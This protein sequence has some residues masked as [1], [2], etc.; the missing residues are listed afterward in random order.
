M[1]RLLFLG[2]SFA[3]LQAFPKQ[4]RRVA[5]VELQRVQEGGMPRDWK[6]MPN[7]GQGVIEIHLHAEAGA[8][9]VMYVASIGPQVIVL[10]CFQKKTQSTSKGDIAMAAR[11]Y[12]SFIGGGVR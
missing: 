5:G 11:R 4:V 1:K 10:H 9:R 7:V 12:R 6:P 8:F 3:D 2:T